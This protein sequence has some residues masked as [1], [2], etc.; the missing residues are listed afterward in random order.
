MARI[1]IVDVDDLRRQLK[2]AKDELAELRDE[3]EL[4]E[5]CVHVRHKAMVR[6]AK[7]WQEET[8]ASDRTFPDM[9][10]LL[11]WLMDRLDDVRK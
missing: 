9:A 8:G 2:E 11:D 5:A 6:A 10:K 1:E 3:Q 7:F 4:H